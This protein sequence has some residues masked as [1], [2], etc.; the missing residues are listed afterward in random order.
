MTGDRALAV[1]VVVADLTKRMEIAEAFEA[2][3][4]EPTA[5]GSAGFAQEISATDAFA[6]V[7]R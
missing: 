7:T 6:S 2:A 5:C 4:F 3:G 1:L